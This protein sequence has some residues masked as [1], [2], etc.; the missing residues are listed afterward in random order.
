VNI[1]SGFFGKHI[2]A[3]FILTACSPAATSAPIQTPAAID[4]SSSAPIVALTPITPTATVAPTINP[5]PTV[6]M[7]LADLPQTKAAVEQFA[8]AMKS[9]GFQADAEQIR[10]GLTIKETMRKDGKKFEIA[11]TQDGYPLMVKLEEGEWKKTTIGNI[12]TLGEKA[13]GINYGYVTSPGVRDA[14]GCFNL[15]EVGWDLRWDANESVQGTFNFI[16]PS[17]YAYPDREVDYAIENGHSISGM[18][19][20]DWNSYPD[21]LIKGVNEK[22]LNKDQVREIVKNRIEQTMNHYKGKIDTWVVVNEFHPI[23]YGWH[24]DIL[25]K[26]LGDYTDF[27]FQIARGAAVQIEK[28]T[29][30]K[31]HLL[32]ND[33][34]NEIPTT[35]LFNED[36]AIAK[37]LK[38]KGL[39]DGM[40]LEMHML[41]ADN[42]RV[43]TYQEIT[44]AIL[45]YKK[46][47]I[48]V[49]VTELDINLQKIKGSNEELKQVGIDPLLLNGSVDRR[50]VFQS[51]FMET[52][53]KAVLDA[54]NVDYITFF[55]LGDEYSWLKTTFGWANAD[56]TLFDK[57]MQPK[58]VYYTVLKLLFENLENN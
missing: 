2:F 8:A 46:L 20:L 48:P 52:I 41:Q 50:L 19:L 22:T 33:S 31:I 55:S 17:K 34:N 42:Q 32:Y 26:A 3:F 1:I 51:K 35:N 13:I 25:Q 21:W 9:A 29:G 57:Q 47:G 45:R 4:T 56:S 23:S 30:R 54:D 37:R 40:G 36:H 7:K 49:Y 58:I 5:S 39:L 53:L 6:E 16:N 15:T 27:A 11:L 24:E 28:E 10:L 38:E 12:G 43:E 14:A 44:T 18:S